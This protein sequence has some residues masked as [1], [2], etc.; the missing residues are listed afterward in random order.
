[1]DLITALRVSVV[2]SPLALAP[3]ASAQWLEPDVATLF[4]RP[5]SLVSDFFGWTA[6][7]IGD[8]DQDGVDDVAAASVFHG[9]S[10]VGRITGLSGATGAVLW[11]HTETM[12]SS[13]N[14]FSLETV[15]WNGDGTIDVLSGAPFSGMIGGRVWVL[16]GDDGTVL[17]LLDP[18]A[19]GDG[20][21]GAIAVGGD[22]DGD[23][24]DDVAI[25]AFGRDTGGP[26]SGSVFVYPVGSDVPITTIDGVG[27]GVEFGIGLAFLGDRDGDGDD[28]L[29]IG[30]REEEDFWGGQAH[31]Y[32]WDTTDAALHYT[33]FG[34]GMG[35]NLIG[36]RIDGGRDLDGDGVPDFLVGD[37]FLGE[38]DV[39]SGVDGSPLYTFSDPGEEGDLAPA[40]IVDDV[41][42]DGRPDLVA[43]S[44]GSD[45]AAAGA[46]KI[47][48]VSGDDGTIIRT[49][50]STFAGARLG[51]DVRSMGDF[52]GDGA[53]DFLVGGTGG[54]FDGPPAGR[55]VIIAGNAVDD[56]ADL[57]GDGIV[58]VADLLIVLAT[59]GTPAGDV[60]GDGTTDLADLLL[61]LVAWD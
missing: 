52:N 46:G 47:Y 38:I 15:D 55:V 34:V 29:V 39:F 56:P 9:S 20:F 35:F 10:S 26:E 44:W 48:L 23:G 18:S 41:D 53:Q 24:T 43:G 50:T 27:E 45:D 11:T 19:Q 4:E 30:Q 58:G 6:V 57:D 14:G 25:G 31:V 51:A 2:T 3:L 33:V 61:V 7:P 42:G 28:E 32:G 8:V 17:E 13:I 49:M 54:G 5:S 21:G 60:N 12:V 36:D 40:R 1:M 37:M 59:W 16:S 22:F